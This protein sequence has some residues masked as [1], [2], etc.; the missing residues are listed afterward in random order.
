MRIGTC[1]ICRQEFQQ[2]PR[3]SK[4]TCSASCSRIS[5]SQTMSRTNR[6]HASARMKRNNP[7][8]RDEVRQK[9]SITH[10]ARGHQP[11]VKG[12][13]GRG[14]TKEELALARSEEHT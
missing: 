1:S 10:R 9:V 2:P 12:G 13:N 8:H 5:N 6:K 3:W 14:P 4:K 7:M 11:I